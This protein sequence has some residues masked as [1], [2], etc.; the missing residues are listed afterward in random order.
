MKTQS[1]GSLVLVFCALTVGTA[2]A[3]SA[4]NMPF[5]PGPAVAYTVTIS[6]SGTVCSMSASPT[7]ANPVPNY[8]NLSQTNGDYVSNWM[9]PSSTPLSVAFPIGTAAF[10]GTPFWDDSLGNWIRSFST[11]TPSPATTLTTVEK[12]AEP[13]RFPISLVTF[14]DGSHCSFPPG[15]MGI[16][17]TK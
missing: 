8:L 16:Q 1:A 5:T 6:G 11:G 3:Q 4:T 12:G 17:V 2:L 13:I 10:P 15:G 9:G 14:N 7:P